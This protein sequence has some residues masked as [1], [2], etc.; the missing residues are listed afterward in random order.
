MQGPRTKAAKQA[1]SDKVEKTA[2]IQAAIESGFMKDIFRN[3]GFKIVIDPVRA[4][5]LKR[6]PKD[7]A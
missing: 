6:L 5:Y 2:A 1:I 7:G 3:A 4:N